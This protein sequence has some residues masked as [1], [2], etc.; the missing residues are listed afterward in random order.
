MSM[1]CTAESRLFFSLA[2]IVT[3]ETHRLAN[4]D[5]DS[6]IGVEAVQEGRHVARRLY[7]QARRPCG[8]FLA[9]SLNFGKRICH[10]AKKG[11]SPPKF[12]RRFRRR[13]GDN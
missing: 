3:L 7:R 2:L 1:Y 6:V 12:H 13:L 8:R 10:K 5:W 9:R 4:I 11:N